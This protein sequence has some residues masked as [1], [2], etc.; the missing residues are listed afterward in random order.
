M[1]LTSLATVSGIPDVLKTAYGIMGMFKYGN[2]QRPEYQIPQG[3]NDAESIYKYLASSNMPAYETGKNNIFQ[4]QA[5]TQDMLMQG[6]GSSAS[7]LNK[8]PSIQTGTN[9]AL[10]Q[11][12]VEN[13]QF[14][15]G[16]IGNLAGFEAGTKAGYEDK[17]WDWNKKEPYLADQMAHKEAVQNTFGGLTGLAKTGINI[18][19][20][21]S[22]MDMNKSEQA[23]NEARIKLILKQLGAG[24]ETTNVVTNDASDPNNV[25]GTKNSFNSFGAKD[26]ES[27]INSLMSIISD[28]SNYGGIDFTKIFTK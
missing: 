28:K 23:I 12:G 15:Q 16:N 8:A 27:V 2:T 19:E 25:F 3:V 10:N 1:D 24:D 5:N 17:A 4:S 20:A 7:L 11:L 6:V 9:Q 18:A 21:G 26:S 13:A 14:K 22:I